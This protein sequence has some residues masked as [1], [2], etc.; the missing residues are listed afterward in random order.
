MTLNMSEVSDAKQ[1]QSAAQLHGDDC[2][3]PEE[4]EREG[5]FPERWERLCERR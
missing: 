5:N 2:T 4:S 1:E 3:R